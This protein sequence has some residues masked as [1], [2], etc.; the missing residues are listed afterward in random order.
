MHPGLTACTFH[1]TLSLLKEDAAMEN[2][3]HIPNYEISTYNK[4]SPKDVDMLGVLENGNNNN[5]KGGAD[6]HNSSTNQQR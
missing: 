2:K 5:N 6:E 4:R 1:A 3:K